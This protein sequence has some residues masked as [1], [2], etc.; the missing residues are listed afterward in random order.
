MVKRFDCSF[1]CCQSRLICIFAIIGIFIDVHLAPVA[2]RIPH[3]FNELNIVDSLHLK[4]YTFKIF[5]RHQSWFFA[6]ISYSYIRVFFDGRKYSIY[7]VGLFRMF[8]GRFMEQS[9]RMMKN[10]Y[11]FL[12]LQ[13]QSFKLSCDLFH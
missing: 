4:S 8:F 1:G 7:P 12:I 5:I 10:N 11:I 13:R 6:H 3:F 9:I 2:V